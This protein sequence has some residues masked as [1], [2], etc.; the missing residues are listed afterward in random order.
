V[1]V[2]VLD[3]KRFG[4][5]LRR[6]TGSALED[7]TRCAGPLDPGKIG[8]MLVEV[9]SFVKEPMSGGGQARAKLLRERL[10]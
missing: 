2:R 3:G 9:G 6:L 1:C 7:V 8:F 5:L 10:T 4:A